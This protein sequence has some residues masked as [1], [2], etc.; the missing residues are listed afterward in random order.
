MARKIP[1]KVVF[2]TD[3]DSDYPASELNSHSPTVHGWRSNADSAVSPK[4]IV[5]RFFHPARIVRIQVLAHQYYIPERIELWIHYSSKAAPST[6]SSQ[7]FEYM[8]FVALSDNASTNYTSRELQSVTVAPKVGSHLKL[9]LGPA[10]AN[11]Y[12]KDSQ[13]A[14]LAINI[15]GEELTAEEIASSQGNLSAMLN[16]VPANIETLNSTLA[17][18]CDDLS[19][20]MYVE[21]SIC[22]VVRKMELLKVQAVQD[23]RFEY[24]RKLKLCMGALRTAG[25]RLGRYALAKR[26]AVQAEDFTTARLRKEQIEMY[27]KAVFDQLRVELLLQSDKNVT[28]NDSCS[29]LYASKPT[30]PSPPSLQDVASAL[31]GDATLPHAHHLHTQAGQDGTKLPAGDAT[32]STASNS[33]TTTA[34]SGGSTTVKAEGRSS[35]QSLTRPEEMAQS[36]PLMSH[37]GRSPMRSPTNTGSLR[38]R[39]KSAPRNSYEDYDERAIPTLGSHANDFLRECQGTAMIEQ[40]G[41]KIRC[42]LNDRERRQAA[43]PILIFGMELVELIYSR[44][45][46][47]REEGLIRLRGILKHEIEPEPQVQAAQA[48]PNK[49]CRGATLLL[50]RGVRDAVFSVFSQATETVRSLFM[51][52]VPNRVSPSEV[53]RSVDRLLPELLS[54]SGDPSARVHTLA[55][56]TILSI[57]ACPEVREQHLI[58]PALSRPVGNGTHPRLALSRMQMLE[59]LVLSQGISNDKQSGLACRTLSEAGCSGIHHP[60]ESVRKVAE[61]V[62]LLV[63]KVNPRLVRKQLPPDDDITRRNLLYRQLFAEF[64]KIDLQRKKDMLENKQFCGPASFTGIC[65][66][67]MSSSSKSSPPVEIRN[68]NHRY[69]GR[70]IV[71][72]SDTQTG[73]WQ[74]SF[75]SMKLQ[76]THSSPVRRLD[77]T[78]A[79]IIKSKSGHAIGHHG[80]WALADSPPVVAAPIDAVETSRDSNGGAY[81]DKLEPLPNAGHCNGKDR[82]KLSQHKTAMYD[83]T[84]GFLPGAGSGPENGTGSRKSSNSDSFDGIENEIKN[85]RSSRCPFCDWICHGDPTQLDKHYWKACPVLTKCPQCS[86]ILEVAALSGHLIHE[87]EAKTSY[88]SCERCTESVHKD[89]YEYHLMEDFCRELTTGA[90]RCPLC[91]DDVL[92]PLD[93]GWKRHLLSRAGC[94]GNTRP[95]PVKRRSA[96]SDNMVPSESEIR[97]SV[98]AIEQRYQQAKARQTL[99]AW[100]YGSNL[101]EINLSKKTK[102]AAEFAEVA[103]TVAEELRQ[104]STAQLTDDSLKRRIKKLSKLNYAALPEDQFRQLLGA[105]ANMESNYAKAKF[106][107]YGDATKCDL[108]LDPELTEIFANHRDPEEL[109]HYWVQWYNATGAPVRESFQQYVELNRQA[110]LR[111]N[112]SSGAEVWLNEYD[113]STFEQQVDDVIEQIRPLYE[114]LHAYVRYKLRQKYGDK[115]VSPTGPIPMHLLGN[116]WAQTWD[117]IAD[118]TT[119]FPEKKLLD[120]TD[121]MIRQGYT[122]IKMFQMGDDFFTS[123]NMTKLPQSFWEKSI[124][125]KP[126]DGRDLVCHASAW[127]FYSIDDVRIKQCT[128]VNMREFFVVHHELGHIQY[129]LQYQQQPV[130]FRGGANPG[131]HEAVGDV[132]SLSVAT[133]K[134]LKKVGLLKDYEEDEQVKIN[135]FYRAGVTK[136]VFLPFAYTLD[137]YRWGVF[138][139]DIKPD[140]Y[141]C[142]FWE[143][144]SRYG[145]VEPPV[146]RT[147]QDFDP[148]AKYHVSADV[149]Y[150]RYFVS[151]VIQFQ[152]HRAACAL[153]GEYVKGDPEKSLNNCD[154]YQSTAA[155]NKLKEMLALGSSKPWPDAM[156]VLTGERKMSADAILEYFD[157]LYK[158]LLEENK[159]LGAHVGW[160]DSQNLEASE[161]MA[162]SFLN[163]LEDDILEQNYNTTVKSWNYETNITDDTLDMRNDAVEDQSRFLKFSCQPTGTGVGRTHTMVLP[164]LLLITFG[165]VIGATDPELERNELAAQRY[166]SDLEAEILVRNNNATELSWAYESNITEESLKRRNEAASRNANFFKEVARELRLYDF[167]SF[168]DADL[169]RRIK[170]L[171]DLGYAA[172][173]ETKFSQLVDAISRM[174]ENYATAKVCQYKNES[175]CN[176]GLEPELT[177]TLAKS[178]DP[179]ELKH[180]WVQWHEVAGK[181]VRKDFDEYVT[182][183]REA[184]QLNNFTS[185][186]EYWLDAYEDDTFEAQVDAAIEQIRPLYE[187]IH[188]YVRYKLRKYYGSE[189]VSEKGPI[190]IHLLGNMWGQTW[191]NI[192]DITTPFPNKKLLDVTDEMV[193]QGYTPLKMFQMGDEFFQSLN[194]TKLPPT[195]WEKSI[196][197]KPNDGRELVCHAS[198]WD[199]YKKD[200]V[201]IKQCTRVNME[202]FFTVHHELGH[203]QYYLQYQHLPSVYREGANPGFHEAVGDV[204]SLSVSTPKH[205]E[206]IGLLKNY[207][208][209]EESKLNQFYQAGL[210]KLVFLPFAYTLDKYRW[211]IFRGDVK[212][213][214]YNCKFWEMRTKYSGVE[215]PVERAESDFDAA[216]KYHVSADVEYLRYFVSYIVQFQFH[217]AACE[218]AGQYVKGDPEKTVNNCDIYQSAEAGNALKA[219][220]AMGSSKPWPDAMEVLTGQRKMSAEA[221]IEYFQP[222]YDWLVKENKALGAYVGWE[223]TPSK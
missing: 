48:G 25:E 123:L 65:S 54:K 4:E 146:V 206:K 109:K 173:D 177:E 69:D 78:T 12:N 212:P 8:G 27:R 160:T 112:F 202:D 6:P 209:D 130:V 73:S 96:D 51:E 29:E 194:M 190:P 94:L 33:T 20:S 167:N 76:D 68:K 207:V 17:S 92:L 133:P 37:K 23:E 188:A 90:A 86:Q 79:G 162:R 89:L 44:Q 72:F 58:A 114:Q 118:F 9:R 222:L 205:L 139:G 217:R 161:S 11:Q 214:H 3:E 83:S 196:L 66:P 108:S 32:D 210:S 111:N 115:L 148:P 1:F 35:Q 124:L 67:P 150:L 132:L 200:D 14:L 154:I 184:A 151:Y 7:S 171:T 13:V 136:L 197:E 101:T 61:R 62:L 85:Y 144:R 74:S 15:L 18:A 179:E 189:I 98:E 165:A 159:R 88:L 41:G 153:A 56:H 185:G 211:E 166:V 122:P 10:H 175:N 19:Y 113:D 181:P 45:F 218:K 120:V 38:R 71:S 149:E 21:E 155:G 110:A 97:Q 16:A 2:A 131:F 59:Q 128:R 80:Q 91:H 57:A 24:A 82:P 46:T 125:V 5:L 145:G 81:Y 220:L 147:E 103:K 219:M 64:D 87:C 105:I 186:A 156:E 126:T 40:D 70:T 198:A 50:H 164:L 55:Q 195:F 169:K 152:F 142:K 31:S 183:N 201:R 49:I 52:F 174:Q 117:N 138:R 77:A 191:D 95:G 39:N 134:H 180:Y 137:K 121:E 116:L 170:K 182:L 193:R 140:E 158:W 176:F 34:S 127:D 221:L 30:L 199:F 213:D 22:D 47:D 187:Q 178:R 28:S 129:Y 75:S 60:A 223:E 43:L 216:A 192:A 53:A 135:Q 99:A 203:I 104:F 215:P 107:A 143:L 42:K 172:L 93:G 36:S 208:Q 157:P 168:K 26:Q 100:E 119:P 106:C 163:E 141:N 102:A 63:Y 84:I 204:L